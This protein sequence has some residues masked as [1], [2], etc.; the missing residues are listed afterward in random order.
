MQEHIA[1]FK[2]AGIWKGKTKPQAG[3]IITYDWDGDGVADHIGMVEKIS[4]NTV[5]AI[6]GNTS[7]GIVGRRT[8]AWNNASVLG[9]AAPKYQEAK[10][11]VYM[12]EFKKIRYGDKGNLVKTFQ[13]LLKGRGY[14]DRKTGNVLKVDGTWGDATQRAYEYFQEKNGY[15]TIVTY[16]NEAKWKKL[17]RL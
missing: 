11:D 14:I 5:T 13:A 16:C 4:G 6:E 17:L 2:N 1:I 9:Y 3:W 12:L 15:K 7:G 10:K 8:I